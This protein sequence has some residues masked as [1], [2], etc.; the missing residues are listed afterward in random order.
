M[1]I[2]KSIRHI[3]ALFIVSAT[4]SSCANIPLSEEAKKVV[5][6]KNPLKSC[7]SLGVVSAYDRNGIT[8]PYE[9]HPYLYQEGINVLKNKAAALGGNR[10]FIKSHRYNLKNDKDSDLI[11]EHFL[12]GDVYLCSK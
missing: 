10:L 8:Q 7:K 1:R 9:S 5:V 2:N 4:L 6:V 3:V 11:D 12:K